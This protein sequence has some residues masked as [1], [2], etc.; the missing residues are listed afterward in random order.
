MYT[1]RCNAFIATAILSTLGVVLGMVG[2]FYMKGMDHVIGIILALSAGG[3]F[4]MLH[5]EMIPRA[6][7]EKEW[8]TT[9]G[10]VK[11]S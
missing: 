8:I 10:A 2:L 7:E 6:H 9:F 5:H 4:Y 3:I 11:V 1:D